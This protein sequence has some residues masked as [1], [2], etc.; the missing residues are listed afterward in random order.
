MTEEIRYEDYQKMIY[1]AAWRFHFRTGLDWDDLYAQGNLIYCQCVDRY[2]PDKGPFANWLSKSLHQYLLNY[3]QIPY[4]SE[5]SN[6]TDFEDFQ[7]AYSHPDNM[8]NLTQIMARLS[9]QAKHVINI[10]M[11]NPPELVQICQMKKRATVNMERI[12]TYLHDCLGWT[13]MDCET[14]FKEIKTAL[15]C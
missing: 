5:D 10:V 15:S 1:K 13:F 11:E 6:W 9:N 7:H 4:Q 12:R 3:V 14:T 2:S 8:I